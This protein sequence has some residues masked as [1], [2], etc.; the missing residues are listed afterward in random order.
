MYSRGYVLTVGLLQALPFSHAIPAPQMGDYGE[1]SGPVGGVD[2]PIPTVTAPAGSLYGSEDL[3]GGNAALPDV[4]SESAVV[5]NPEYVNGQSA[6]RKLGLYLDFNS[7]N[8]PQPERGGYGA[9]DPG[10]RT[11]YYE[12]INP[13]VYAV[14]GTDSGDVAQAMWPMGLSHNRAGSEPGAGWARQQNQDVLPSATAMAGVDMRLGPNA[15]RELHWHTANEWSLMLKG[16]VRISTVNEDGATDV[17]DVCAGDVWFF[18]SGVPHSIQAFDEGCEFLLVFD[19]GA[20]SED[21]TFLLSEMM[22][23][24]PVSVLSKNFKADP[25]AFKNIP[26]DELYIFNGTP[27]PKEIDETQN[28]TSSAGSLDGTANSYTYHWSEQKPYE[29]PGGSVKILDPTTFPIASNFAAALVVVQPG[30][31]REIHWHTTSPEW[32]YFLQGS[33]R[34]TVFQAPEAARTFDFTAGGVGYIPQASSHYV[35]NTGTE[36]VIFLEVLQATKFSDVSA[37]QWLAL[38]PKQVVQ[39]HL[40]LP[41]GF[42]ENLPKEKEYIKQGPKNMTALATASLDDGDAPAATTSATASAVERSIKAG[43]VEENRR[44]V[45]FF[46]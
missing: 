12:R 32:N 28:L 16:C 11:Y 43:S 33:A 4:E 40:D 9:T 6:D 30:A 15:Y 7:V 1:N 35:E 26:Q 36:D 23:R 13:D 19:D 2:P 38:T 45:T 46:A 10:P 5:E 8:A 34:I 31:M 41:E 22:L 39:D 24:T 20:F 14:P 21:E 3:L 25:S 37:A 42:W 44:E 18:P 17:D 27:Q 29:T